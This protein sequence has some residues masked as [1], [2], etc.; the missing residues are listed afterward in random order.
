MV[1]AYGA[2][3]LI[4]SRTGLVMSVLRGLKGHSYAS[5]LSFFCARRGGLEA[6]TYPISA[7]EEACGHASPLFVT[8][9]GVLFRVHFFSS[10]SGGLL[11]LLS[12]EWTGTADRFYWTEKLCAGLPKRHLSHG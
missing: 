2:L 10:H 11:Q 5:D 3:S 1:H 4:P 12:L 8:W 7:K 6:I 9:P